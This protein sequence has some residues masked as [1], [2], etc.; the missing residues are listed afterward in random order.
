[1]SGD[2]AGALAAYCAFYESLTPDRLG[3]L[4]QLLA[5]DVRF[6]DPFNDVSGVPAVRRVFEHMFRQCADA[7]FQVLHTAVA[8][9]SGYIQWHFHCGAVKVEGVSRV[10]FDDDG[11]VRRHVD[12]WDPARQ[13][14]ETVPVI[15]GVMRF[16]R[17]RLSAEAG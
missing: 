6:T 13:L 8:G 14:Y 5:P 1:M 17:R 15:G 10:S 2:T 9:Q 4:D 3:A 16:I 12:Y 7:R 11:R